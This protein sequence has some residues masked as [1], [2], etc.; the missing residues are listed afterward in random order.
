MKLVPNLSLNFCIR[1][2]VRE[3]SLIS[4]LTQIETIINNR[5]LTYI[6]LDIRD[7]EPLTPSHFLL[8][9]L[10]W[11][12]LVTDTDILIFNCLNADLVSKIDTV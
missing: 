7:P 11:S 5:P 6:S 12:H 9:L 2:F 8:M 10:I 4:I 3:Q 1:L